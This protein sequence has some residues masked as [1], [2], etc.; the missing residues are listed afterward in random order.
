MIFLWFFTAN[1]PK[2]IYQILVYP[3]GQ[4]GISINTEDYMCLANDQ[5]L[6]DVII[7][8]YLNYLRLEVLNES[9]RERTHFFSSFFY[10]SLTTILQKAAPG[11]VKQVA[12]QKRY[13]RVKKWTKNVNLFEKDFI[14]IPVNENLHW[15]LA[16]ICY[17]GLM[18]PVPYKNQQSNHETINLIDDEEEETG[19]PGIK[20]P[21]IL[22]FNSLSG[23]A[24]SRVVT[25]LR[26]YLTNEYRAK[27]PM[28]PLH[29]FNKNNIMPCCSVKVPQQDNLTDCGLFLLHYV[30]EFFL[31]PIKDFTLPMRSLQNWFETIEVLRK[32]ERIAKLIR[33]LM[34]KHDPTYM[35]PLPEIKFP[36]LN[37]RLLERVRDDK[38]VDLEVV[39][40]DD[41]ATNSR[42]L[43][44]LR[45]QWL[46]NQGYGA[47][48]SHGHTS[49]Q[50][51]ANNKENLL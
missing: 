39:E 14:I 37:G 40:V 13:E 43:R 42:T 26:E 41:D 23:A 32:R 16:I 36:T 33:D 46:S 47:E 20:Q 45:R 24:R 2:D 5:Y 11:D 4:G 21:C 3:Q 49:N 31:H 34:R 27:M 6:N 28:N 17:P 1:H 15:F 50:N 22:I 48:S 7:D 18:G 19:F 38:V 9:Q 29:T 12:A 51:E 35:Q 30:E 25:T 10:E 44:R 8:F